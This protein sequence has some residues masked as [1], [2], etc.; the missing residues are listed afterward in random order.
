MKATC[1]IVI[2]ICLLTT[3]AKGQPINV[4]TYNLR[5]NIASDGENAW[6]NRKEMVKQL[7]RFHEFD[8]FGTQEGFIGQLAYLD[9]MDEYTFVG[10][11]RDDGKKAGEHSAIFYRISRFSLLD[12]G[13]FWL[14][15]TPE[16]PSYG[17]D[18]KYRRICSW[19]KF[20]DK[21]TG[22]DF[23]FFN[24]HFDHEA[25]KARLESGKLMVQKINE[26]AGESPVICVGDFNSTP[27]TE[28]IRKMK[29]ILNDSYEITQSPPYGPVGTFNHFNIDSPQTERIDYVFVSNHF[30][31]I[32]YGVLTDNVYRHYPSDHFPVKVKLAFK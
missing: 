19:A 26:I 17:W 3:T 10:A 7:I 14:S 2:L 8:L 15:K 21:E 30:K 9:E 13:N 12:K 31:V 4:A 29:S 11:G 32:K 6:P 5:L 27:D 28:Q 25:T 18:A 20:N 22:N 24:V 16:K 1:L 23:F